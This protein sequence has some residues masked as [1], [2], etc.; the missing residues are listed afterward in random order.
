MA[1]TR[2]HDPQSLSD[3]TTLSSTA[4]P[5]HRKVRYQSRLKF[6]MD[7]DVIYIKSYHNERFIADQ[8]WMIALKRRK[9]GLPS[10]IDA[11]ADTICRNRTSYKLKSID[12]SGRSSTETE[13][14]NKVLD[15]AE[16]Q[17][18]VRAVQMHLTCISTL[19]KALPYSLSCCERHPLPALSALWQGLHTDELEREWIYDT[20]ASMCFI[21]WDHLTDDEKSRT[22]Q[23]ASQNFATAGGKTV[24]STAVMCNVPFLGKCECL[25]MEDS[26]PAISVRSDVENHGIAF[27]YSRASGPTITLPTGTRV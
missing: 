21:G 13:T 1:E 8:P 4:T 22:Y 3:D 26:P 27:S 2:T 6:N 12:P 15:H 16:T 23:V 14:W 7:P 24:T 17:A 11:V 19:D 5:V 10:S 25:V 9:A 18:R 20:G